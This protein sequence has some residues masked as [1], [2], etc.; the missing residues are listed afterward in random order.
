M[1]PKSGR[2]EMV[3]SDDDA[4]A[5]GLVPLLEGERGR[6]IRLPPEKRPAALLQMRATHPLA[7]L[8]GLSEDDIRQLRNAAK[9]ERRARRTGGAK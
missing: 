4:R 5:R 6:L 1:D 8:P 3:E 9:Q 2:I 7:R